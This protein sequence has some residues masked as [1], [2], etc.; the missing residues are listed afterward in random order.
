MFSGMTVNR[1]KVAWLHVH[2]KLKTVSK[3]FS[4]T[5]ITSVNASISK[6]TRIIVKPITNAVNKKGTLNVISLRAV[7]SSSV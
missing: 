7:R 3:D 2:Y 1:H 5:E 4:R 6:Y